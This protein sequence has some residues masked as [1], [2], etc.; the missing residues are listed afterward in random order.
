MPR[1]PRPGAHPLRVQPALAEAIDEL[2][3]HGP[4]MQAAMFERARP[5][6]V[7]AAAGF[8]ERARAWFSNAADRWVRTRRRPRQDSNLRP[9]A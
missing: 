4:W 5:L 3:V 8:A 1:V 6:D 9:T 2:G 7:A